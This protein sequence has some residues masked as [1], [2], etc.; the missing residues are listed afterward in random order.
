[1]FDGSNEYEDVL[2]EVCYYSG[3]TEDEVERRVQHAIDNPPK[4][5]LLATV[6]R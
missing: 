1:M 4:T 5:S 3:L 6:Q 2:T